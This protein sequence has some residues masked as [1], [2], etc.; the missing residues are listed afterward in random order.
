M[1]PQTNPSRQ[2]YQATD[3]EL[4]RYLAR[5]SFAQCLHRGAEYLLHFQAVTISRMIKI[6]TRNEMNAG[7]PGEPVTVS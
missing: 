7:E 1:L 2:C 5:T 4:A 3:Y 6:E